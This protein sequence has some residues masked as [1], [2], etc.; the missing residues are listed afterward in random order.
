MSGCNFSCRG[1]FA[2]AKKSVD[3]VYGY[4]VDEVQITGG[5]PLTNPKYLFALIQELKALGINKIGISTNG[6]MLTEDVV[7]K[8]R[9]L[10][11]SYIDGT[12][13]KA[14]KEFWML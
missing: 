3:R 1:C 10:N 13:A 5:E 14:T 8:L 9:D 6:Y 11:I 7:E 12:R 4:L 2:I